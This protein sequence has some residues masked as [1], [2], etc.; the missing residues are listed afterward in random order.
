LPFPATEEGNEDYVKAKLNHIMF[1]KTNEIEMK[2][3]M[4]VKTIHGITN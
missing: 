2:R 3:S 4:L 1:L